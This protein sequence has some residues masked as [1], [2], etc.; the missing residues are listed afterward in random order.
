MIYRNPNESRS[1]MVHLNGGLSLLETFG[2]HIIQSRTGRDLSIR[3]VTAITVS[4]AAAEVRIPPAVETIRNKLNPFDNTV[5]WKFIGILCAVVDLQADVTKATTT[6][7]MT[8]ICMRARLLDAQLQAL[9]ETI[10]MTWQPRVISP[11]REDALIFSNYYNIYMNH[12]VTQVTNGIRVVRLL[13][14]QILSRYSSEHNTRA[15]INDLTE[16][17]C[18]S[19]PQFLLP[20][21]QSAKTPFSPFQ[22]L[23]CCTLLAP[24]YMANQVSKNSLMTSWI[25]RCL[26]FMSENGTMKIAEE[27]VCLIKTN[28]GL[29]YWRVYAKVGCYALAA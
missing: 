17:I 15:T 13:L 7:S 9:H 23:Q 28:P 25:I 10:P 24:L 4:C 19:V 11:V 18:A 8:D 14:Q 6:I 2:Q 20:G 1:W 29:N 16:Q 22:Q 21:L 12:Y 5:K 3:L 27:M 26:E